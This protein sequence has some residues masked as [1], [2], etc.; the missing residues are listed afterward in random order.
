MSD[1]PGKYMHGT[2]M[3]DEDVTGWW[4]FRG[5]AV[6]TR[7]SNIRIHHW[8]PNCLS[9]SFGY[10]VCTQHARLVKCTCQ[11]I[12][13][14]RCRSSLTGLMTPATTKPSTL[15]MLMLGAMITE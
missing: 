12:F 4:L 2:D 15:T 3:T 7:T 1:I 14:H 9:P 6:A 8:R 13:W 5:E 10:G 11:H